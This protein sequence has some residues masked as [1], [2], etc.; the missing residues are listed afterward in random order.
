MGY[1]HYS[2]A[3]F[4]GL[5]GFMTGIAA[6]FFLIPLW[7]A[8]STSS[9]KRYRVIVS[10]LVV[11]LAG[12]VMLYVLRGQPEA[13][14]AMV[15]QSNPPHGANTASAQGSEDAVAGSMEQAANRLAIRLRD[16][17]GSDADWTLLKQSYDFLNDTEGATLAAQHRVKE[18]LSAIET[19]A[20]TTP[21]TPS[22]PI[23]SATSQAVDTTDATLSTK[24]APFQQ[25]VASNSKDGEAWLAIAELNRSARN[26]A[27]AN[28]AYEHVI[29]LKKMTATSWA[30]YADSIASQTKSLN[31][32]QTIAALDAALKLDPN[33]LKALWLK[34]SLLHETGKYQ[35]ALSNWQK[36]LSLVPK[37]SSDYKLIEDN[38]TE[39][40]SLANGSADARASSADITA[41]VTGSIN[42]D[43]G[44]KSK[45]SNDMTLFVFAKPVD[46][47][48]PPAAVLRMP[49]KSWPVNFS[50]DDSLSMMPTRKLSQFKAVNVQA[51]LSRSGQALP[52]AGDIQSD[53]VLADTQNGK[54]LSLKLVRVVE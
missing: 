37:D 24:L 15:V 14:S 23:S 30:D 43:P 54:P 51:R 7:Q 20:S 19:T 52:Q 10:V 31:N 9:L 48:G 45:V 13:I 2:W 44:I 35:D 42:V 5:A 27:L 41:R 32:P 12:S 26:Y 18:N 47:P 8:A 21:T 46:S 49:V 17:K 11:F 16:G 29:A 39:A 38:I 40:R 22:A 28:A 6:A 4:W 50:L 25:R 3:V 53:V 34:A 36:L 33:H 1:S